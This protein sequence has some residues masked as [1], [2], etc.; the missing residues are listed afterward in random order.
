MAKGFFFSLPSIGVNKTLLPFID[1]LC[2]AGHEITYYN[3]PDFENRLSCKGTFN[4]YPDYSAGYRTDQIGHHISY[5]QFAEILLDTALSLMDFIQAEIE[6]ERPDFILHSHLAPWGKLAARYFN[7]PAV[8]LFSTFILDEQMMVPYFKR[9]KQENTTANTSHVNDALNLYRKLLAL[10]TQLQ[11]NEKPDIWDVYVNKETLNLSFINAVFQPHR[12]I[13][14][15]GYN[16][17]GFPMELQQKTPDHAIIYV[18]MGTVLNKDSVLLNTIIDVL[19]DVD[20]RCVISTGNSIDI[21]QLRNI[22][23]HIEL[24]AFAD[25]ES[26]LQQASIFITRGG[27]AS[28]HEA[29]YTLTPMIVIPEIPEQRLTAENIEKLGIGIQLAEQ[30]LDPVLLKTAIR[31]ILTHHEQYVAALEIVATSSPCDNA[32]TLIESYLNQVFT[33]SKITYVIQ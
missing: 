18:S 33:K 17:V 11:L 8:S 9:N 6:R 16:F 14:G 3:T 28:V 23:A 7:L 22:P 19:A 32:V 24:L 31:E 5:F 4:A 30:P 27:M 21:S 26:M 1:Q 15:A 20:I 29:V 10:H 13:L 25:Q 12:E 2:M